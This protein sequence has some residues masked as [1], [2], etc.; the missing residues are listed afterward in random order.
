MATV[1]NT[2]N[3]EQFVLV[4]HS[5]GAFV[6]AEYAAAHPQ[7]V[8]ELILVDPPPA[9][10]ALPPDQMKQFHAALARIRMPPSSNT[11]NSSLPSTRG[12][13]PRA[14][15]AGLRNLARNAAIELTEDLLRYDATQRC[16]TTAAPSSPSSRH[17]T[18]RR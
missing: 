16:A 14:T 1:A 3:L 10:G 13:K 4:G 11:G 9:P 6:A 2:Q 12:R 5:L 18:T 8:K 15:A 7:R 17:A